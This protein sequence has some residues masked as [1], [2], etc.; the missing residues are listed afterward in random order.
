MRGFEVFRTTLAKEPELAEI[1]WAALHGLAT[2]RRAG[3]LPDATEDRRRERVV[4]L[5][6]G[7]PA[8]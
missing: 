8:G 2:L 6:A 7:R 5:L 1:G 3:R 4:D